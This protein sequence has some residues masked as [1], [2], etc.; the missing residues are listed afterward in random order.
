M[1][2]GYDVVEIA[3]KEYEARNKSGVSFHVNL[4]ALTCSC[5]EFQMLAFPCSHTISAALKTKV[6]V[7]DLVI[8]V[9]K[10]ASLRRAYQ[11]TILP[12]TALNGVLDMPSIMS[13]LQLA[14]PA[15]RRPPGRPKKLIYFSRGEKHAEL[16]GMVWRMQ[17][18]E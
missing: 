12:D 14:L 2:G 18:M 7:N 8:E 1:T 16:Y 6:S 15:T 17:M 9:Y 5:F 11:G 10:V 4:G 13:D 3:E